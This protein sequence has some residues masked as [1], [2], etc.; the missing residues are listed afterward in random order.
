MEGVVRDTKPLDAR[1]FYL[2]I[3]RLADS[4]NYGTD[5]SPFHGS[6]LEYEQSRPYVPGDPIKSIDWRVTARTRR[7][8]VK[9]YETPKRMPAFLL[10]DSSA[11]MT[12]GTSER[13]KYE[14]ALFLAGGIAMACLQRISPVGLLTVGSRSLRIEPS[15]SKQTVLQWLHQLRSFR[16]DEPTLLGKRL[17]Q[18]A[19]SLADRCLLIVISDLHDP[20]APQA[21][22]RAAQRHDTVVLHLHDPAEVGLRGAGFLRIREPESARVHTTHGREA[23]S[24]PDAVSVQLRRA[25][26]DYLRIVTDRPYLHYLRRFFKDRHLLGRGAR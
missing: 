16:Y 10:L 1:R 23:W 3:K 4:L 24:D 22:K 15:L 18:L 6:G 12:V 19:P 5:R 8:H 9:E 20:A 17:S 26:V 11:S 14:H 7:V 13:T 21:L 2:A 25:N